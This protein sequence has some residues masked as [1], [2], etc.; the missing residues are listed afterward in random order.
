MSGGGREIRDV[1]GYKID[2]PVHPAGCRASECANKI[3]RGE[4]RVG[5]LRNFDGEHMSWAYK[6]WNCIS[7]YDIEALQSCNEQDGT[8]DLDGLETIPDT[9]KQAVLETL[10]TG[11]RVDVSKEDAHVAEP[12]KARAKKP[13][14]EDQDSSAGEAPKPTRYRKKRPIKEVEAS[15]DAEPEYA[16]KKSKSKRILKKEPVDPAVAK[17]EAMA[18]AM[19]DNAA[20]G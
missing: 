1:E 7:K 5:F 15:S 16:P 14:V 3:V 19:R 11:K 12:K 18:A 4:L 9:F 17:I 6:H 8:E 2:M 13:K 10:R 20:S